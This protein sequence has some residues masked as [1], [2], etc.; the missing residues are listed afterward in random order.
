MAFIPTGLP[1][2]VLI[3]RISCDGKLRAVMR[4]SGDNLCRRTCLKTLSAIVIGAVLQP[5]ASEATMYSA[6]TKS[7]FT[8]SGDPKKLETYLPQIEAGYQTLVDL[9]RN[10]EAKTKD[11]DGDVVRRI[12]GTVGVKSPLFNVRKAFLKSWQIVAETSSDNDLIER[13]ESEWNDVLDGIS[14]V[15]FQLYSVSFTELTESKLSLIKQGRK[16]LTDT[17][18]TYDNLLKDLKSAV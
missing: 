2:R 16:T 13:L 6:E 1:C 5:F 3:R 17:I 12:L 8:L 15:D 4:D 11:F 10:W 18:E 14:A 9:E 7:E